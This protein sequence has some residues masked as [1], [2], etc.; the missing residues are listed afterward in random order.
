MLSSQFDASVAMIKTISRVFVFIALFT[1]AGFAQDPVKWSLAPAAATDAIKTGDKVKAS[2]KAEVEK[3][4]R[5]YALEQP[6]GGPIATT[7]KP[8]EGQPFDLDGKI[9]SPA[10]TTKT[11]PLFTGADDKP[12]VTK[13]YVD[14]VTYTVP[15]VAKS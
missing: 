5:L 10:P 12:L 14:T 8:T 2:L 9:T 6:D 7:I 3:D 4:W 1:A 11:D 15:L 13:Y